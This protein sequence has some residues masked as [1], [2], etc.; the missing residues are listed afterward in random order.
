MTMQRPDDDFWPQTLLDQLKGIGR[1]SGVEK[2]K[3]LIYAALG[4]A[5]AVLLVS[6]LQMAWLWSLANGWFSLLDDAA[7]MWISYFLSLVHGTMI[8]IGGIHLVLWSQWR[9]PTRP[10]IGKFVVLAFLLSWLSIILQYPPILAPSFP[11][12]LLLVWLR[13]MIFIPWYV[14]LV[15]TASTWIHFQLV[16]PDAGA[17]SFA[18]ERNWSLR[19]LFLAT[20]LVAIT[21][22]IKRWTS[23]LQG[24]SMTPLSGMEW[25]WY[26]VMNFG[27]VLLNTTVLV[28]AA[29]AITV[30]R[31]LPLAGNLIALA[32]LLYLALTVLTL[33][34]VPASR[35]QGDWIVTVIA[36]VLHSVVIV[37]LHLLAFRLWRWAGYSLSVWDAKLGR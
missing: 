26:Q 14:L 31:K 9:Y 29:A 7:S 19:G 27:Y 6:A 8:W 5:L 11:G 34:L 16:S 10:S 3:R 33:L 22:A 13:Y 17:E 21:F 32:L 30:G 23:S 4:W 36:Y 15:R 1:R 24:E 37:G 20:L 28:Y 35:A 18:S 2:H 12:S 25:V